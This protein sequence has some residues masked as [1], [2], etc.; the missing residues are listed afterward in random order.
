MFPKWE[1]HPYSLT[2]T[3]KDMPDPI[4]RRPVSFFSGAN[5]LQG[6]VYGEENTKGL[7]VFSH[8]ILSW[9]EDY[10]SGIAELVRRGYTVFAYN[11]TGSANSEGEDARGLVQGVLDLDAALDYVNSDPSLKDMKRFIWSQPG[12]IFRLCGLESQGRCGRSDFRFRILDSDG[13]NRGARKA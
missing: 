7:I 2:M 9:H 11:N 6:Y 13:G 10:L 1:P 3:Y 8:G 5:K 12:R 4:P